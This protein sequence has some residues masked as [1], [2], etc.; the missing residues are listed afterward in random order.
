MQKSR[1]AAQPP[2][3]GDSKGWNNSVGSP[4]T[5]WVQ[6]MLMSE[7]IEF[8]GVY[9]RFTGEQ[10][11]WRASTGEQAP[12]PRTWSGRDQSGASCCLLQRRHLA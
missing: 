4:S 2:S 9:W 12:T 5:E 10:V 1:R 11:Y 6:R 3:G 7:Q 8:T